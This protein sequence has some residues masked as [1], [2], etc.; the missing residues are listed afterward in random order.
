MTPRNIP[1]QSPVAMR[2]NARS[3]M[4][5][6]EILLVIVLMA[7]LF[8]LIWGMI[9]LYSRHYLTGEK[10]VGRAQLVRSISQTLSDDLGAA[11]QDPIHP[12]H[13]RSDGAAVYIRRFGLRGDATSLAIDVVQPNLFAET[14]TL[15]ENKAAASGGSAPQ[16]AQV[17]ELKTIYYE[18]VPL[19]ARQN[20]RDQSDT[21][22]PGDTFGATPDGSKLIGSLQSP[23]VSPL[24]TEEPAHGGAKVRE[25]GLSRRELAFEEPDETVTSGDSAP[26]D[27]DADP[28]MVGGS[29]LIGSLSAPPV[30]SFSSAESENAALLSGLETREEVVRPPLTAPQLAME[31]NGGT[32]W[33]PE[34]VDCRFRYFDGTDWFDEWDS[35]Q[36]SGLPTAIEVDLKLLPLDDVETL[37]NSPYLDRITFGAAPLSPNNTDGGSRLIGSLQ[38]PGVTSADTNASGNGVIGSLGQAPSSESLGGMISIEQ[39]VEALSLTPIM[40]RRVVSYLPT[41]P[42]S[43][44]EVAERR[45]PLPTRPGSVRRQR[46]GGSG[47]REVQADPSRAVNDRRATERKATKRNAETRLAGQR[48]E[49]KRTASDRTPL[50]RRV[51][52]R[53]AAPTPPPVRD[54]SPRAAEKRE[55]VKREA[56]KRVER[57]ESVRE[58][59]A[60]IDDPYANEGPERPAFDPAFEGIGELR[61]GPSPMANPN[62]VFDSIDSLM[63]GFTPQVGGASGRVPAKSGAKVPTESSRSAQRATGTQQSW[64]RGR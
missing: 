49:N 35:I 47:A 50:E 53:T 25:Y 28:Q 63:S 33:A 32:M 41:T 14:A 36:R 26:T 17:P 4:T 22:A 45:Q 24:T 64:I 59:P 7:L 54:V 62:A 11:V 6:L 57:Q 52:K 60:A 46:T 18:F 40:V 31:I 30:S 13:E 44:H 5:L 9:S 55:A 61:Q 19:N 42:L 23:S 29:H 51:E 12:M 37:R 27:A 21:N 56:P 15:D 20:S 48:N 1:V 58:D 3:G 10:R 8:G 39:A 16:K 34:V 43:L 2:R 38:A